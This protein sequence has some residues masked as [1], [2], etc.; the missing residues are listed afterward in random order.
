MVTRQIRTGSYSL[1]IQFK[2]GDTENNRQLHVE[3][4]TSAS[5]PSLSC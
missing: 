1:Q 5:H 2:Y 4:E 3:I